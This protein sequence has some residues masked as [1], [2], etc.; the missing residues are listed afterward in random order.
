LTT[1]HLDFFPRLDSNP[2]LGEVGLL[3]VLARN[4]NNFLNLADLTDVIA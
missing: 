1:K 4:H 3:W 2:L